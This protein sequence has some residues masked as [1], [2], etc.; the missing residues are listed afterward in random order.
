MKQVRA[1]KFLGQHFLKDKEIA[2][3]IVRSL[4]EKCDTSLLLEVGPGMGVLTEIL[5]EEKE[6]EI[7]AIDLDNESVL[8]LKQKFPSLADRLIEGD[9]LQLDIPQ[10]FGKPVSVIGNFPYNISSQIIFRLIEFRRSIPLLVGM[11]Q[12][13]V[14]ERIC[15]KNRTKSYGIL[16]VFTQTW[17]ETEY[18]F[19]VPPEVF[20]PPPKVHSAV[21]RLTRKGNPIEPEDEILFRQVVKTAFN[22]RRKQ[23][24]N[25]LHPYKLEDELLKKEGFLTKRAEE[26]SPADFLKL[27]SLIRNHG[28]E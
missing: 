7:H 14:A 25:A 18:L 12:K 11:F 5:L 26:L 19:T 3:S 23:L 8:F 6:K 2:R 28:K 27:T 16:S 21:I 4:I 22:Q 15:A 24:R 10:L 9:F 17:F 13:E 1:K 20:D